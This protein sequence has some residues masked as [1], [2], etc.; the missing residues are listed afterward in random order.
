MEMGEDGVLSRLEEGLSQPNPDVEGAVTAIMV[1]TRPFVFDVG[2]RAARKESPDDL[3]LRS[4]CAGMQDE[5][6]GRGA[7]AEALDALAASEEVHE[8]EGEQEGEQEEEQEQAE[9]PRPGV[10]ALEAILEGDDR[11]AFRAVGKVSR[12]LGEWWDGV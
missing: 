1:R 5:A 7:A 3:L 4:L 10:A 6:V 11:E 9:P 8:E 2:S 12:H